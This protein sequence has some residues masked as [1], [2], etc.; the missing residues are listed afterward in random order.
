MDN[1]SQCSAMMGVD[2]DRVGLIRCSRIAV[3]KVIYNSKIGLVDAFW[4]ETHLKY[5]APPKEM[6]QRISRQ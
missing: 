4:C 2:D 5:A 3:A 6:I 1:A